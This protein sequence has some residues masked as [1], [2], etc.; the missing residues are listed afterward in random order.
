MP[1][2]WWLNN[3]AAGLENDQEAMQPFR[4]FTEQCQGLRLPKSFDLGNL[5]IIRA[6]GRRQNMHKIRAKFEMTYMVS[7]CRMQVS[8]CLK[9]NG[10]I[11]T[12]EFRKQS[13]SMC[14][15][16]GIQSRV[17]FRGQLKSHGFQ[18]KTELPLYCNI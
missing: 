9:L 16:N 8:L 17:A 10:M 2:S 3:S 15:T 13:S 6:P 12:R 14:Y 4:F 5:G 1:T 18:S 11:E 7:V